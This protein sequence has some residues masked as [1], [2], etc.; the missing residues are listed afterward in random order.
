M[1]G[2]RWCKS[3]IVVLPVAVVTQNIQ[4]V[5]VV[6]QNIGVQ[7]II[8]ESASADVTNFFALAPKGKCALLTWKRYF[9]DEGGR[10]PSRA[11]GRR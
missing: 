4:V 2:D 5:A 10:R 11:K 3:A 6:T 7:V 1:D 9:L 8:I